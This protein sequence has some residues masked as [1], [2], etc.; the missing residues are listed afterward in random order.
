ML[1][2][3]DPVSLVNYKDDKYIIVIN[4]GKK[5]DIRYIDV[6]VQFVGC[7]EDIKMNL[8][9]LQIDM[10]KDDIDLTIVQKEEIKCYFVALPIN[11]GN[12]VPC[13]EKTNVYYISSENWMELNEESNIMKPII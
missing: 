7:I 12:V 1:N 3:G 6:N 9:T 4:H 11:S 13:N 5:C 2:K 10:E 8:H